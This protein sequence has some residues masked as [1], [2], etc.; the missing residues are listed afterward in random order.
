MPWHALPLSFRRPRPRKVIRFPS[1]RLSKPSRRGNPHRS[2]HPSESIMHTPGLTK[3]FVA[4][5]DLEKYSFAA[6]GEDDGTAAQAAGA[7]APILGVTTIVGAA[8]GERVDVI[9]DG[10]AYVTAGGTIAYGAQRSEE[11]SCRERV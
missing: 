11:P 4:D 2:I 1:A 3:N 5:G 10:I 9:L 6:A 7:T 8:D